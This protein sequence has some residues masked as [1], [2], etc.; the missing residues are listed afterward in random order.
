MAF[1]DGTGLCMSD[2]SQAPRCLSLDRRGCRVSTEGS[3]H[4]GETSRE[5]GV[6]PAGRRLIGVEEHMRSFKL[7]HH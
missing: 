3:L 5:V 6:G 1:E 2:L 7:H 4:S